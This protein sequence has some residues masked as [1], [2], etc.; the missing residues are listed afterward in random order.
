[1]FYFASYLSLKCLG[2]RF[3]DIVPMSVAKAGLIDPS[4]LF[5][6]LAELCVCRSTCHSNSVKIS[7]RSWLLLLPDAR[8]LIW[9]E[10]ATVFRLSWLLSLCPGLWCWCFLLLLLQ[11]GVTCHDLDV[12]F[13]TPFS[14]EFDG[15]WSAGTTSRD[16]K[17]APNSKSE[18]VT[19]GAFLIHSS[20]LYFIEFMRTTMGELNDMLT[21]KGY[22]QV[23]NRINCK[24]CAIN[25]L[26]MNYDRY[27]L[28]LYLLMAWVDGG[29]SERL[30]LPM[31]PINS[32]PRHLQW[33]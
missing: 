3:V 5:R 31:D 33:L 28:M 13:W 21:K 22:K 26:A 14:R 1:M 23:G 4:N 7:Q 6:G 16:E 27:L 25:K 29:L 10:T 17:G 8:P 20:W 11:V 18:W 24:I 30:P 12:A 19:V 9:G 15:D 32:I 2:K